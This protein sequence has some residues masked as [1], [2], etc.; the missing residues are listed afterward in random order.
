MKHITAVD[1]GRVKVLLTLNRND[2][3][4][5]LRDYATLSEGLLWHS[6]PLQ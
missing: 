1:R 3:L 2:I 4:M 6:L 5:G